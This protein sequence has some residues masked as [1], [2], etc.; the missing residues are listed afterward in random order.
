MKKLCHYAIGWMRPAD[1]NWNMNFQRQTMTAGDD[2]P[3]YVGSKWQCDKAWSLQ[4]NGLPAWTSTAALFILQAEAHKQ[5]SERKL[6]TVNWHFCA[7]P[8][9][10]FLVIIGSEV[11][12]LWD[13]SF[14]YFV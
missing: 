8:P 6:Q 12:F 3:I 11:F 2:E 7:H 1:E 13:D 14:V 9:P 5:V 4:I 10:V